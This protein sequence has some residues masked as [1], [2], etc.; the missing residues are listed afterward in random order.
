MPSSPYAEDRFLADL[1]R[2][3]W[4]NWFLARIAE[5]VAKTW[6]PVSGSHRRSLSQTS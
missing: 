2:S 4:N 1:P 6:I 3:R 5:A